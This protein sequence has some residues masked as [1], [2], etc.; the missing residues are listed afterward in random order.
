MFTKNLGVLSLAAVLVLANVRAYA[1]GGYTH[2]Y[3]AQKAADAIKD[4]QTARTIKANLAAYYLGA[5]FPDVGLVSNNLKDLEIAS[6]VV[7]Q[8]LTGLTSGKNY[9]EI[10]H[11]D[12]FLD[13]YKNVLL[14]KYEHPITDSKQSQAAFAFILGVAT[15]RVSDDIWHTGRDDPR[16][17]ESTIQKNGVRVCAE[18]NGTY[19]GD[20]RKECKFQGEPPYADWT[21]PPT[22]QWKFKTCDKSG[23]PLCYYGFITKLQDLD[24]VERSNA[25]TAADIGIDFAVYNAHRIDLDIVRELGSHSL[26]DA[27]DIAVEAIKNL[28]S[29]RVNCLDKKTNMKVQCNP[30]RVTY[31]GTSERERAGGF[32]VPTRDDIIRDFTGA[33]KL[34]AVDFIAAQASPNPVIPAVTG[35]SVP[36]LINL[37][38]Y[39]RYHLI[40][41][42]LGNYETDPDVGINAI[43]VHV[44]NCIS[45][46][47]AML[48]DR[49]SSQ[50]LFRDCEVK[51]K[52]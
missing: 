13:E 48:K 4:E 17:E 19:N 43:A 27:L 29:K 38:D 34:F 31:G 26:D 5:H 36:L 44:T 40:D 2:M 22:A 6:M 20:R 30:L 12:D 25:H 10:T 45:V 15:H 9:G 28:D 18:I 23:S 11:W 41:W 14:A 50:D 46:L 33:Y 42:G 49:T 8:R 24:A 32:H 47:G 35:L 37:N 52:R 51:R 21:S 1:S 16:I 39:K 3:I 7:Q